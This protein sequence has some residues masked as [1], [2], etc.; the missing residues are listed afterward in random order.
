MLSYKL[1]QLLTRPRVFFRAMRKIGLLPALRLVNIRLGSPDKIYR[2]EVPQWPHPVFIRGGQRSDAI[3]LYEMLVTEEYAF[4]DGLDAPKSIIDGGANI[5]LAA[6]YFLNRYPSARIISVEPFQ[7]S[8]DVCRKNLEAYGARATVLEGAI[9]CDEG[10]VCLDPQWEDWVNRVRPA[11]A[12]ET[13]S[14]K[15]FTVPSLIAL[16]GGSVDLLKLD[17][18]GSEKEIFGPG[19]AEWLPAVRNIVIELH[20]K[21]CEER[22]FNAVAPYEY[23]M[24]NCDSVYFLRN[25]RPKRA[26]RVAS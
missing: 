20:G 25:L 14:A 19:A 15:A 16:C 13:G 26:S 9:W 4:V 11:A 23:E 22:F 8:A 12:G 21:D 7:G 5:G 3:V 18:E 2:V 17:V 10:S 6:V 24:T 1:K